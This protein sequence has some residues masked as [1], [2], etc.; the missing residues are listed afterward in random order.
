[1]AARSASPTH[2]FD[3]TPALEH[4]PD[5]YSPLT[6]PRAMGPSFEFKGV[7]FS[8]P[9]SLPIQGRH[10]IATDVPL[11]PPIPSAS[12]LPRHSFQKATSTPAV[13]ITAYMEQCRLLNT[14][15]RQSHE[16]ER[17]TW[18]IERSALKARIA[19]LEQ[20][21]SR[22]REPKRRSSND[23]STASLHSFRSNSLP[24]AANGKPR[25]RISP[26]PTI[27]EPP[28]WKGPEITPPVTR[29]F[30]HDEEGNHLP[31]ISEDDALPALSKETSPSSAAP[32]N[33]PVPIEQV[34]KTLDGITL[35][36]A[37]LTSSFDKEITSPQFA[38]PARSPSPLPRKEDPMRLDVGTLLSPL[39]DKLKRHAGH[40]PMAF[41]GTLSS[42]SAS[43]I[44][45]PKQEKP[46][47]PAPTTRPP[48]RP[49]EDSDSYFS[50]SSAR[51]ES[52][53]ENHQEEPQ[54]VYEAHDDPALKGP[55]MLDPNAKTV[56]SASFLNSLDARLIEEKRQQERA[57]SK[58][59][60]SQE[61][62]KTNDQQGESSTTD[63][64][65]P[66]LRMKNSMNFG[67][68]WG[69]HDPGRML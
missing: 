9:P 25:Q 51:D 53:K 34:D 11:L 62:P 30:S 28:V 8:D 40:T 31:S 44:L 41:D 4:D 2:A 5:H 22:T 37:A 32:E 69:G 20:K 23:S 6:Q 46:F 24:V 29:V 60:G 58:L 19:E 36:S 66:R 7:R 18:E 59:A 1:M 56:E 17:K 52:R 61:E 13:D 16:S 43:A 48:L 39:D 10:S 3:P 65:M 33:V 42:D 55:L 50:F 68:A 14:Q 64:E 54:P 47:A 15:L 12:Q 63:D 67:S 49:S 45:T 27:T 26:E 38:S 35:K 21:L 57:E